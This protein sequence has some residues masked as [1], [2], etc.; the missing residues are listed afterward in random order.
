[1]D[2]RSSAK[3]LPARFLVLTLLAI[4]TACHAAGAFSADEAQLYEEAILEASSSVSAERRAAT[5]LAMRNSLDG[6]AADE[7]YTQAR[8]RAAEF[9]KGCDAIRLEVGNELLQT[10]R[11]VWV[12]VGTEYSV[13]LT[14]Q[15]HND[16]VSETRLR[17]PAAKRSRELIAAAAAAF[18]SCP[19]DAAAADGSTYC[20]L[21]SR[22][23]QKEMHCVRGLLPRELAALQDTGGI[24]RAACREVIGDLLKLVPQSAEY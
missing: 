4:G 15:R 9:C 7:D 6:W 16:G 10:Y 21:V 19:S 1:M 22:D 3:Q 17:E 20:V 12:L 8:R 18:Q 13:A 23:G 5:S 11:I 14:N 24:S 2:T